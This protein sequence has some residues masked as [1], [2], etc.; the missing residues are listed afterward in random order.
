MVE[1]RYRAGAVSELDRAQ[2]MTSVADIQAGLPPL[3]QGRQQTLHA[4]AILTG[5]TPADLGLQP[6]PLTRISVP[7]ALP[8]GLPSELL[9]RRPDIR[10]AEAN[11][12]AAHANISAARAALFPSLALTGQGGYASDE[13]VSLIR[14]SSS[15]ISLGVS[16]LVPIFHGGSLRANVDR[17]TQ[18]YDELLKQYH[19][20]EL[21]ALRD[22]EDALVAVQKLTEEEILLD[23]AQ[24]QAN[25]AFELAEIR[26]RSGATDATTML[27]AQ[28]TWL[29]LQDS[30]LK[31]RFARMSALVNL[32]KALGGGR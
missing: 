27:T 32:Y 3:E 30:V 5:R 17:S 12:V 10:Q 24:Q 26:Y 16:L 8:L 31:V 2:S 1:T 6:P 19:Q 20:T 29:N 28:N 9:Q 4:L 11:L 14:N 18:R 23:S 22:V 21:G 7:A 15:A 25:R 13:L